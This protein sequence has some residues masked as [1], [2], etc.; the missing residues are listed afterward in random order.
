MGV[1][2]LALGGVAKQ[3]GTYL[4]S[5]VADA[6]VD[7][8][9]QAA[10]K[11][12]CNAAAANPGAYV[13]IP[14]GPEVVNA[15]CSPFWNQEGVSPPQFP[16]PYLGGQCPGVQ[17]TV[18]LQTTDG[19]WVGSPSK[20]QTENSINGPV[21]G[22]AYERGTGQQSAW[23]RVELGQGAPESPRFVA[24]LAP[25]G[26]RDVFVT[27]IVREDGLPDDCGNPSPLP[28]PS[29]NPGSPGRFGETH[30][31]IDPVT[32]ISYD[33]DV[34]SPVID[35]DAGLQIPVTIDANL[36]INFPGNDYGGGGGVPPDSPPSTTPPPGGGGLGG[37]SG[38]VGGGPNAPPSEEFPEPP[39]GK[40]WIGAV[41]E[42][43]IPDRFGKI[44]NTAP[45]EIL[46]STIGNARLWYRTD[47]LTF[48]EFVAPNHQI[49]EAA[50]S[51]IRQHKGLEV[52]GVYVS[53]PEDVTFL[54][55]PI[56]ADI[57]T[58]VQE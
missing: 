16:V 35:I 54:V 40:E 7:R 27:E 22:I 52:R 12:A 10:G 36:T 17:Y 48:P 19:V 29:P 21:G 1:P 5:E 23:D 8:L 39:E 58:A 25:W 4:V 15:M 38:I 51:L 45:I 37:G 47:S 13:D 3:V 33:I 34:G 49:R 46:P 42:L 55:T 18:K 20:V 28:V 9:V 24:Y 32:N 31:H 11:A 41:I 43:E 44:P 14:G 6:A 30:I 26:L 56:Y 53:V 2:A 57:E 50:F